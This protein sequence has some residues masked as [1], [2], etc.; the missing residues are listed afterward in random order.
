MR[1]R[2]QHRITPGLTHVLRPA[3]QSGDSENTDLRIV[4]DCQL[5]WSRQYISPGSSCGVDFPIGYPSTGPLSAG[6]ISCCS[7]RKIM[8]A[9]QAMGLPHEYFPLIELAPNSTPGNCDRFFGCIVVSGRFVQHTTGID[10]VDWVASGI[11]VAHRIEHVG[12]EELPQFRVVD[13]QH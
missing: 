9:A 10:P 2:T 11:R 7:S 4:L 1:R 12:L 5:E 8:C 6:T 3:F 13:A